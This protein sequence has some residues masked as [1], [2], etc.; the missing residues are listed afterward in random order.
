MLILR[1][2]WW[3]VNAW[4]ELA[5][6][7]SGMLIALLSYLPA[8]GDIDF[9]LRLAVTAFGSAAVWIPAMLLTPPE[10]P[11]TLERFYR[12][13]RPGGPGWR[14]Q[15]EACGLAAEQDLG[16]DLRSA[17]VG[18]ALLFA[19]MLGIGWWILGVPGRAAAASGVAALAALRLWRWHRAPRRPAATTG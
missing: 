5:A 1:W 6:M 4:A 13:T 2:F 18:V 17:V 15:R 12:R 16:A 14:R 3:R 11:E 7:L 8:F 9:G 19:L 10:R